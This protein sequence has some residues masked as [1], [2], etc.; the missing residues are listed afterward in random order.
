V[1]GVLGWRLYYNP[2]SNVLYFDAYQNS[3]GGGIVNWNTPGALTPGQWYHVAITNNGS[4]TWKFYL[5]GALIT[6]TTAGTSAPT[7]SGSLKLGAALLG[8]T[9]G[10]SHAVNYFYGQ[11]DEVDFYN[12]E[13]TLAEIQNIT[14]MSGLVSRVDTVTISSGTPGPS[15]P[16]A[17]SSVVGGSPA[18]IHQV[19]AS[20][21]AGGTTYE[22]PTHG[23]YVS[24]T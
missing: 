10:G 20:D 2:P 21:G 6:T 12:V 22:Y 4:T 3:G 19:L 13:L 15:S 18:P 16:G 8:S 1:Y 9:V 23:V 11:L 7:G 24:G 14:N 5:N 17:I